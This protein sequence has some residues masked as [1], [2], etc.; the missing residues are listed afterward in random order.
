MRWEAAA[1]SLGEGEAGE[2]VEADAV[3]LLALEALQ[4]QGPVRELGAAHLAVALEVVPGSAHV[5]A[6]PQ[7]V[8][9]QLAVRG[10]QLV[11]QVV[12]E[13]C[14]ALEVVHQRI[15]ARVVARAEQVGLGRE[16]LGLAQAVLERSAADALKPVRAAARLCVGADLAADAR[17]LAALLEGARAYGIG[18]ALLAHG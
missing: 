3:S 14:L 1:G 2:V 5:Q 13:R 7:R 8:V 12:L 4:A 15:D 17:A 10:G 18:R 6:T 11:A 16:H 9:V